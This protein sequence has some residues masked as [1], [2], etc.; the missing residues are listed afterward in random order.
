MSD[1][2]SDSTIAQ[3]RGD[4]PTHSTGEHNSVD[5][6]PLQPHQPAPQVE[7][8][9]AQVDEADF[10]NEGTPAGP[11]ASSSPEV[12][13]VLT[14]WLG[15]D[16]G[17]GARIRRREGKG[18]QGGRRYATRLRQSIALSTCTANR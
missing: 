8:E 1:N 16:G 10:A 17:S 14:D 11:Q 5:Q 13:Y 6:D 3:A 15:S 2:P 7:N 12:R 4:S 18:H 9:A